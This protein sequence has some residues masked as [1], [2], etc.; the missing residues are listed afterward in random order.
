MIV[1]QVTGRSKGYGFIEFTNYK[2]FQTAVNYKE[3]IIF[4]NQKLVFNSAKN[5]YE[6]NE[7]ELTNKSKIE[8]FNN[9]SDI[10]YV[11]NN[12]ENINSDSS[13]NTNTKNSS[14]RKDSHDSKDF[15]RVKN[16]N[17]GFLGENKYP[18]LENIYENEK[19]D[20]LTEQIKTALKKLSNEFS[21]ND[22]SFLNK[23]AVLNYYCG[24]FV[25]QKKI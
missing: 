11:N 4:G 22:N 24:N 2:E 20:I 12:E 5:R 25:H 6:D 13:D 10:K 18:K 1:N 3:P 16:A 19:N 15:R 8:K 9:F 17:E 21:V 23:S 14:T 7:L